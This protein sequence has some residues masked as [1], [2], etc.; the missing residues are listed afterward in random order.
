[1]P[2]VVERD[3]AREPADRIL[4]LWLG[5]TDRSRRLYRHADRLPF[6]VEKMIV[7]RKK[8]HPSWAAPEIREKLR[9]VH[10]EISLP[11]ISPVRC[12]TT[13]RARTKHWVSH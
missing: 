1:M 8:E 11:A 4:G 10:T 2:V 13:G 9:R 6:Q 5:L 3:L 7:Q 12:S